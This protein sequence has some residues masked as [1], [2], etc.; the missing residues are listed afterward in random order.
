MACTL[1]ASCEP[2]DNAVGDGDVDLAAVP[3]AADQATLTATGSTFVANL[4]SAWAEQY[5]R[6]AP[7]VTIAYEAANSPAGIE[8]LEAGSVDF[9]TSDLPLTDLQ[10]LVLGGSDDL[11][12]VPW[13]AGAIA[14]VYN[15]PGVEDL[16]LTPGAIAAIFSGAVVR[17]DDA[18]IQR[19]NPDVALPGQPI[20]V[21][22]RADPSGTTALFTTFLRETT[23]WRI[24]TGDAIDWPRGRGVVG[25]AGV[26]AAV[27]GTEGAIGYVQLSY[28]R[29]EGLGVA[30]LR[31]EAGE[32]LAPTVQAV[33]AALAAASQRR[34]QATYD[35]YFLPASPGSYALSTVSYLLYRRDLED[36]ATALALRHFAEWALAEGQRIAE[37]HGYVPV[38]LSIRKAAAEVVLGP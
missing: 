14:I 37:L 38:P 7:G 36:P 21:V 30:R 10:Q 35:L 29:D 9:A 27:A 31:N 25:S 4:V 33:E 20:S 16:R 3:G 28:A 24:G 12:Q 2:S 34:F 17:W 18:G 6:V 26:A 11:A 8:A 5:G 32:F 1:L 23:G 15:L 19:D 22:H 13:A